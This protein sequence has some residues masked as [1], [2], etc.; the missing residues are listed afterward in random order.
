MRRYYPTI[1]QMKILLR[2]VEA[3]RVG[4]YV[5][6]ANERVKAAS[7]ATLAD[8]NASASK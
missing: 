7:E 1:G 3:D 8:I 2:A 4:T 6:G 5:E